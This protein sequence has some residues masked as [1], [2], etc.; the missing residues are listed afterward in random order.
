MNDFEWLSEVFKIIMFNT[1]LWFYHSL[2][3]SEDNSCLILMLEYPFW[4][5][6][7][8]LHKYGVIL[9]LENL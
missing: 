5:L 6:S 7:P 4:S 8:T 2:L 1:F 3:I 9:Q